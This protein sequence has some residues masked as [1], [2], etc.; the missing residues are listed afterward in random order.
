MLV[1]SEVAR[2]LACDGRLQAVVE[3]RA[4]PL[5]VGR[6]QRTVPRWLYRLVRRRDGGCRFPGCNQT[7]WLQAHHIVHWADGGP[8]DY[9]NIAMICTYH[10][11]V[12]HELGW[13]VV[14]TGAGG[15]EFRS[16]FGSVH[17]TGPPPVVVR[18][19]VRR[20]LNRCFATAATP[21]PLGPEPEPAL[22]DT[23]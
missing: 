5:G 4:G 2:R 7:R 6:T 16:P 8:T 9:D 17:T 19:G 1:A 21:L 14:A 15:L 23:G 11:R 22:A 18:P 13:R 12:V 20:R 10:H 3:G